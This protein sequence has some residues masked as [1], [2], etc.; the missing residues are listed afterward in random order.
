M[1]SS[2]RK[3]FKEIELH[4]ESTH[5]NTSDATLS[6]EAE[7]ID[8][9]VTLPTVAA[10]NNG[11]VLP[12]GED[13]SLRGRIGGVRAHGLQ[14]TMTPTIGRPKLRMVKMRADS[15]LESNTSVS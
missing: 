1:G 2:A 4:V 5:T 14:L 6:A 15:A 10:L 7:N 12:V 3:R 13:A 9:T 8:Q 11:V